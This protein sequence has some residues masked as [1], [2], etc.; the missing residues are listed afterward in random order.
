V[1]SVIDLR[2]ALDDLNRREDAHVQLAKFF[3]RVAPGCIA[4][5]VMIEREPHESQCVYP[6]S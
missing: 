6:D 5:T 4:T 2:R 1:T 3:G